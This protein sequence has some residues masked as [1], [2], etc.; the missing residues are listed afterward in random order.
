MA[1]TKCGKIILV[2]LKEKIEIFKDFRMSLALSTTSL[3]NIVN[4]EMGV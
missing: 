1:L 2:K 3:Q 4:N